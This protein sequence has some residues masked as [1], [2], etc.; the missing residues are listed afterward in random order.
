MAGVT[1]TQLQKAMPNADQVT[2][3]AFEQ[4]LA[5][6]PKLSGATI[7]ATQALQDAT[8]LT[9]SNNDGFSNER[10]LTFDPDTFTTTD[11]GPG[12]AFVVALLSSIAATGGYRLEFNLGSDTYLDLP[13][14]GRVAERT[15]GGGPYAND[16]AAA[17]G[18]IQVGEAYRQPAG[19][20]V[21]RQS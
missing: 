10:V 9:L 11:G 19:V 14:S 2:I 15:L 12:N 4:L 5:N 16:A 21:W 17:A 7:A 3:L 20:V 8:A 18:G 1:R 6:Y 13:P